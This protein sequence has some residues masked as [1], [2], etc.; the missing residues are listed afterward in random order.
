MRA[1]ALALSLF[2]SHNDYERP[3]PLHDA[4]DAGFCAVEADVHL[5]DGELRVA[6]RF[7]EAAP[8]RTLES[9]YLE[10]LETAAL[11]EC[12]PFYLVVDLKGNGEETLAA[13]ERA[14]ASFERKGVRVLVSGSVPKSA[15][16][17]ALY[18]IDGRI[19]DIGKDPALYPVISAPLPWLWPLRIG[20]LVSRAHAHGH[21]MRFW[22]VRQEPWAVRALAGLDVDYLC[23][24]D[25]AA[26]R[27]Q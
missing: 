5:Q 25:V 4:L 8:G 21:K 12:S 24:D 1:A 10:P 19:K 16:P 17:G 3:R 18:A 20:A 15:K 26:A 2:W 7:W 13:V 9:L 23:V 6:H 22:N 11:P 14:L 27:A